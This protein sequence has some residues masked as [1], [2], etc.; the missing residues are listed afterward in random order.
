MIDP[1]INVTGEGIIKVVPDGVSIRVRVDTQG[2]NALEVKSENDQ[3]IDTVLKFLKAED[4]SRKNVQTTRI[5]L[6]KT[7]DYNTKKY[8]Y[9]AD[10]TL[11]ILLAD[12]GKYEHI[13]TGLLNS[14][15]NRIDN[16]EFVSSKMEEYMVQARINAIQ[17]AKKKAIV[18]AET[19][20]QTVGKAVAI[21]E[22]G[23]LPPQVPLQKS[24][25]MAAQ[26]DSSGGTETISPGQL[27]VKIK[28]AVSFDLQ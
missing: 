3:S 6:N 24:R 27:I 14:G 5:N 19:L 26:M 20:K 21:S 1:L 22:Q 9:T 25:M 13:M 18:Y 4:I 10:Q 7:Y 23:S 17:D 15:I 11:T 12:L 16:V 8:S 2:K 28:V